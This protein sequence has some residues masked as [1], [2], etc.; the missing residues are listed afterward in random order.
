[1][2]PKTFFCNLARLKQLLCEKINFVW[3]KSEK[4]TKLLGELIM[5]VIYDV[6]FIAFSTILQRVPWG[7]WGGQISPFLRRYILI[8]IL[9]LYQINF[10][11]ASRGCQTRGLKSRKVLGSTWLVSTFQIVIMMVIF[12]ENSNYGCISLGNGS[13]R[14]LFKI[15]V[16]G[17]NTSVHERVWCLPKL[18]SATWLGLNIFFERT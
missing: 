10:L 11:V 17:I 14:D 9:F 16:C 15:F 8:L 7:G 3:R 5:M 6:V 2:P 12:W 18:F 13:R 1:M 4:T